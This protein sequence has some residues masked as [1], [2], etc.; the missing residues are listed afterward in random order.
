MDPDEADLSC[1]NGQE[2]NDVDLPAQHDG[3]DV[4]LGRSAKS[5]FVSLFLPRMR[6]SSGNYNNLAVGGA[7][8]DTASGSN[9]SLSNTPVYK[10]SSNLVEKDE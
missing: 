7:T 10:E 8:E 9:N 6:K 5:S 4:E 1:T 2:M 3:N